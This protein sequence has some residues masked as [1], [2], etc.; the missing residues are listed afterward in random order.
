MSDVLTENQFVTF[1]IDSESYAV[2]VYKV[3][4][5][6]EVPEITK[7]PGMPK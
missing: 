1:K 7:V 3:R 4:E 2:N 6:L 5:I